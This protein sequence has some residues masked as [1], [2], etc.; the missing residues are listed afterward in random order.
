MTEEGIYKLYIERAGEAT[1]EISG[2]LNELDQ[3][4]AGLEK[5]IRIRED[6]E[7]IDKIIANM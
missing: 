1:E 4:V 7:K 3:E 5:R 6:I 2:V